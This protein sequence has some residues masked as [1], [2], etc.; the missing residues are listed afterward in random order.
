MKVH[1]IRHYSDKN[2]FVIENIPK[3]NYPQKTINKELLKLAE[4]EL[5]C[6]NIKTI[7]EFF[8]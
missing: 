2:D 5:K 3:K 8:H 7:R 1:P 6:G 4:K